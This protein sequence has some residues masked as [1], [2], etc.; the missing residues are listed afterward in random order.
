MAELSPEERLENLRT[1]VA[2]KTGQ[3][4]DLTEGIK[5]LAKGG[6]GGDAKKLFDTLIQEHVTFDMQN[7]DKVDATAWSRTLT[8]T[9]DGKAYCIALLPSDGYA[10]YA[11][12]CKNSS[13]C[14]FNP[15]NNYAD[16]A[17][18]PELKT[19]K[20][21]SYYLG[22]MLGGVQVNSMRY[23]LAGSTSPITMPIISIGVLPISEMPTMNYNQY[24]IEA[25]V[26]YGLYEEQGGS[27][28]WNDGYNGDLSVISDVT[29]NLDSGIGNWVNMY[30][31]FTFDLSNAVTQSESN[32]FELDYFI[33]PG[34]N[35][36]ETYIQYV[37]QGSTTNNFPQLQFVWGNPSIIYYNS[38]GQKKTAYFTMSG[39]V[40]KVVKDNE[41]Q[42]R[43]A[44]QGYTFTLSIYEND[45]L[46]STGS[47]TIE[48]GIQGTTQ[49][50]TFNYPREMT[51][52]TN[53]G[54][55]RFIADGVQLLGGT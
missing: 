37:V 24:I 49:K 44:K 55:Y 29:F 48:D 9:N 21:N 3:D 22:R 20:G 17:Y 42:V 13:D 34:K 31:K 50:L 52:T 2:S 27:S 12:I 19:R 38:S 23:Y 45:T 7:G 41:Y 39:G 36:N 35:Y 1:Y 32:S 30:S 14:T 54:K 43:F 6:G 16:I 4:L 47:L 40:F 53:I 25:I 11:I 8:K 10:T 26:D 5:E 51:G 15:S 46:I 28:K 33:T 18:S